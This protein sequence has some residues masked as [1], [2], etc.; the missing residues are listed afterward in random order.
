VEVGQPAATR[1]I[2]G[3]AEPET[4]NYG[5]SNGMRLSPLARRGGWWIGEMLYP[6][7]DRSLKSG[8]VAGRIESRPFCRY[9]R[10]PARPAACHVSRSVEAYAVAAHD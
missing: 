5:M 7:N 8:K 9:V 6:D 1:V 2:G 3:A 10:R 4:R